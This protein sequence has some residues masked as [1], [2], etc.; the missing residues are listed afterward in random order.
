MDNLK[1]ILKFYENDINKTINN[2]QKIYNNYI[3][4]Y[5]TKMKEETKLLKK[6]AK[7]ES[8]KDKKNSDNINIIKLFN[9]IKKYQ[10]FE[11]SRRKKLYMYT[12]YL[13]V[14]IYFFI[15][16]LM[17]ILWLLYFKKDDKVLDWNVI[18]AGTNIATYQ[19]MNNYLI[20]I[21][22]NQTYEDISKRYNSEDF[23]VFIYNKI[24]P[25]Y[26]LDKY[27]DYIIDVLKITEMTM[28]YDCFDFYQNLDNE[29]LKKLKK[30]FH[31]DEKKLIYTMW[32]FCEWSNTMIFHN[33]KTVYLQLFTRVKTSMEYFENKEYNDIIK[34]I[35]E[36]N[37]VKNEIMYLI[38]YNYVMDI[39]YQNIKSALLIMDH[40]LYLNINYFSISL[41]IVLLFLIISINLV[42]FRNVNKDCKKFIHISKIFKV[43][44]TNI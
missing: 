43:C 18:S 10:I 40:I 6:D 15:Y 38:I 24:T 30:K 14:F 44:N 8:K 2:L 36:H 31:E 13:I 29:F 39:M 41:F 33:F 42:Y 28:F 5:K 9:T 3:D 34:Y 27:T 22:D 7:Y 21:Y 37:V 26:K 32:F 19:L 17:T 16:V 20:M 25:L 35:D 4:N 23:M 12:L 1:L 11:N